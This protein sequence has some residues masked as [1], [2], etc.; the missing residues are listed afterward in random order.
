MEIFLGGHTVNIEKTIKNLTLRGF[1]VSRFATGKEAADYICANV[2]GTKVGIGGCKTAEQLGLFEK[3]SENNEV[4]W[5]WKVPGAETIAKANAAPVYI[6]SANAISEDGEILNIDG[7]GNRLAGQVYGSKKVYIVAGSNKLC[8]D[9]NDALAR[10][11]NVAA[12][13]NCGRF[14]NNNPCKLDGKCH[15]CRMNTRICKA[16][17]VLWGPMN[18]MSTEV[19]LIDEEYGF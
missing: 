2:S 15:D 14:N 3:L 4:F 16:L 19:I 18:G 17:L 10:A 8:G 5:H 1:E 11:R 9:F 12:V 6:T 13:K 7:T